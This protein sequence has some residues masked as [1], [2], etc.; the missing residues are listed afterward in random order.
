MLSTPTIHKLAN[1]HILG[2]YLW[3]R[4]TGSEKNRGR[5]DLATAC[6][7]VPR[8]RDETTTPAAPGTAALLGNK[9]GVRFLAGH[10]P[11]ILNWALVAR[12]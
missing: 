1:K 9:Q 6:C 8:G 2:L 11:Q 7:S 12:V 10:H 4:S 5:K 3:D